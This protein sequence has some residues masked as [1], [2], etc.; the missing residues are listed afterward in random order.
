MHLGR[1]MGT[2]VASRKVEGLDGVRLLYVVAIDEHGRDR[3][4]PFVAADATQAGPGD[5]VHLTGSREASLAMPEPFVPVD[6]AV[7]AI[8]DYVGDS[9]AAALRAAGSGAVA[10]SKGAAAKPAAKVAAKGAAKVAAKGAAKAG[11]KAGAK[12]RAGSK[13][14]AA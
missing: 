8:V 9:D 1:V 14:G 5:I 4:D 6:A 11:A 10:Q 3:G 12:P 2:V 13:G 7:L